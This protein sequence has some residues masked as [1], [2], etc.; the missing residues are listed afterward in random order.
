MSITR[1]WLAFFCHIHSQIKG[2]GNKMTTRSIHWQDFFSEEPCEHGWTA[3][4]EAVE[5]HGL[6]AA[7]KGAPD[8]S[9]RWG[10]EHTY[11]VDIL[12]ILAQDTDGDVRC[13]VALNA[14][15]PAETLNALTQDADVSVR[16][17]VALN[18]QTPAEV[19]ATLATDAH[20]DVR[21]C[22][23]LN[24]NT[25]AE[26]LSALAQDEDVYVRCCVVRNAH[27]PAEVLNA[28]AQDADDDVRRSVVQNAHTPAEALNALAHD[29]DVYVRSIA[30]DRLQSTDA[31]ARFLA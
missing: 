23:A 29:T 31:R 7:V 22:V 28:L 20:Y 13:W 10:A 16:R 5:K 2:K 19:L 1:L 8:S 3:F 4:A 14:N 18:A 25:S 27:T 15:T 24:A 21:R 9:R 6:E 12:A 17:C 11:R 26:A 30:Q